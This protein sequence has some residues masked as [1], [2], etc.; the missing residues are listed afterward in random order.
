MYN[1]FEGFNLLIEDLTSYIKKS[2]EPLKILEIGAQDFVKDLLK[3]SKPK[4]E[5]KKNNYT[6]LID[7]F[8]YKIT[9]KDVE[10]GW[11]K[12][13]GRMVEL[14]TNKMKSRAHLE[15]TF[16]KNKNK[17]YQKMINQFYEGGIK[18]KIKDQC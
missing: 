17:Y 15:P 1:D 14:G 7:T 16:N 10:V 6:H 18:W 5:I 4:S 8:S 9:S 3:L 13:Y 12:Y 11:G 2:E